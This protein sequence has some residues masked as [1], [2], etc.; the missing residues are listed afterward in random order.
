[1]LNT[2]DT[3]DFRATAFSFIITIPDPP[4]VPPPPP[5][6]PVLVV[7]FAPTAGPLLPAPPPPG[8]AAPTVP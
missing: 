5:P 3:L 1:M 8:P 6:P 2:P 4:S 7:P